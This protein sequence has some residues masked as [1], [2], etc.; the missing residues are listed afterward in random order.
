MPP[1]LGI[2]GDEPELEKCAT[3]VGGLVGRFHQL[4]EKYPVE[5]VSHGKEFFISR[6]LDFLRKKNYSR[7]KEYE[8]LGDR[9]WN[10]VKDLPQGNCHGDLHKGNLLQNPDGRIFIVDFDTACK[11]PVMFDIMVMC[12]MTDFF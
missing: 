12:D 6:Y 10:K 3:E 8:E 2:D 4:M 9:L 1:A 11:A 7:I 5:M